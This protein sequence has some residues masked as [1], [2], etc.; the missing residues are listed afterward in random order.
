MIM[1]KNL[2]WKLFWSGVGI[3][4]V[5]VVGLFFREL[6][7]E[8]WPDEDYAIREFQSYYGDYSYLSKF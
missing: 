1:N 6:Y 8:G 3:A 5:I 7:I 2:L 4:V